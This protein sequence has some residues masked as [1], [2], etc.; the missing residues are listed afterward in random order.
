MSRQEVNQTT[1]QFYEIHKNYDLIQEERINQVN[2]LIP[3]QEIQISSTIHSIKLYDDAK[4]EVVINDDR[5]E[6]INDQ[7]IKQ[8]AEKGNDVMKGQEAYKN[9]DHLF[10]LNELLHPDE[11]CQILSIEKKQKKQLDEVKSLSKDFESIQAEYPPEYRNSSRI[12]YNDKELAQRLWRRMKKHLVRYTFVRPYGLDNGGHW[13]PVGVNECFRMSKYEPGN[14]FKPHVDGQFVRNTDERSVYTLLIYLNEDFTGGETR[15]LTVVNNVEEGQGLDSSKK[16]KKLSRSDK[17]MAKKKFA[18]EA[19]KLN[20]FNDNPEK[21]L[22]EN[23]TLQFKHLC[24]VSPKIGSAAIFNHDLYHEGCPVTNGIKYILRTEIMFKRVD[25]NSV[26]KN[27]NDTKLYNQVMAILKQSDDLEKKGKIYESTEYY[28]KVQDLLIMNGHSMSL[29]MVP[30]FQR[31]SN[32]SDNQTESYDNE[33]SILP[34]E[35]LN[36]IFSYLQDSEICTLILPLD[37]YFHYFGRNNHLWESLYMHR[38]GNNI[39]ELLKRLYRKKNLELGQLNSVDNTTS[40][41][42]TPTLENDQNW[43]H[44]YIMKRYFEKEFE[45]VFLDVGYDRSNLSSISGEF[46]NVRSLMYR[47][48]F[49]Q[50]VHFYIRHH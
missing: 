3:N 33:L 40:I 16:V 41:D 15:F 14:Y 6:N 50:Y 11:C 28:R 13:I 45:P 25:S 36:H 30:K 47:T 29:L 32:F 18:K 27:K 4:K 44:I 43:Y 34:D 31:K 2:F 1:T 5:N 12:I 38:W 49:S 39:T 21:S 42:E 23:S 24:S 35:T 10:V 22:K 37:R 26:V 20:R 7:E 17:K 19:T 9:V 46:K 8:L 48:K